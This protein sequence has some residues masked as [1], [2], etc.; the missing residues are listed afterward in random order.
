MCGIGLTHFD[1]GG[2]T[3]VVRHGNTEN[4]VVQLNMVRTEELFMRGAEMA[5]FTP[6]MRTHEGSIGSL[7]VR[8]HAGQLLSFVST[9][10]LRSRIEVYWLTCSCT[11][12]SLTSSAV[13]THTVRS[14]CTCT[15]K[16]GIRFF[17]APQATRRS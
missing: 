3:T 15:G 8:Y 4:V 10:G 9:A 16:C 5:V 12:S 14:I 6:V 7:P 13:K 11:I 17:S 1:I 2:Y